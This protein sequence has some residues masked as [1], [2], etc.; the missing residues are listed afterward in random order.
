VERFQNLNAIGW[1]A[2]KCEK[3]VYNRSIYEHLPE[4]LLPCDYPQMSA[5]V[6]LSQA[7]GPAGAGR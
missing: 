7:A 3:K 2:S 4:Q 1:K 6:M 5:T